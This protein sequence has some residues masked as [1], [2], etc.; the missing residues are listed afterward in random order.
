MAGGVE[1][2]VGGSH[3]RWGVVVAQVGVRRGGWGAPVVVRGGEFGSAL[4]RAVRVK[5]RARVR[6]RFRARVR[7]GGRSQLSLRLHTRGI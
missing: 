1:S 7:V 2:Q 3:W 4:A 6:F 5:A